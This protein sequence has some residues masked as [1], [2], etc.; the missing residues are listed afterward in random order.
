[1]RQLLKSGD[2][3]PMSDNIKSAQE[4]YHSS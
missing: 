2:S 3:M 1:V 4:H